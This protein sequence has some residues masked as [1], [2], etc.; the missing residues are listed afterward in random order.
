M[1]PESIPFILFLY[2]FTSF[3][4]WIAFSFYLCNALRATLNLLTPNKSM[5]P[6]TKENVDINNIVIVFQ[7]SILIAGVAIMVLSI[8]TGVVI[9]I[10]FQTIFSP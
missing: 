10:S 6:Q 1:L 2:V 3:V 8:G 9:L 7:A 5:N 4:I